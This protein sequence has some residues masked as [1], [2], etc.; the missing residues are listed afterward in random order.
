VENIVV[1]ISRQFGC[2]G[3][4]VGRRLAKRLGYAYVDREILHRAARVLGVGAAE[5]AARDERASGF[6]ENLFRGFMTGS[7]ETGYTPPFIPPIYDRD[8]FQLEAKIM[9]GVAD[10]RSAVIV[11]RGGFHVLKRR[12]G[13]AHVFLH[14]AIDFR[15]NRVMEVY[16]IKERGEAR[17]LIDESDRERRKFLRTMTGGDWNDAR[18]YHL[19]IDVGRAGIPAAEAM[20]VKLVEGVRQHLSP[21]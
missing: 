15:I 14:A 1:T 18:N 3:A 21:R 20:I 13:S 6:W 9:N 12:A 17:S 7:P 16:K 4:Y 8:L 5:L 19:C 11:G 10:E 2:G